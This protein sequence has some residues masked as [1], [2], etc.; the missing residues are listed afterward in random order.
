[1]WLDYRNVHLLVLRYLTR[2]PLSDMMEA[3]SIRK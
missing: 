1:M 2:A 3:R